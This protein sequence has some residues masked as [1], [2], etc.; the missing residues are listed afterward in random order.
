MHHAGGKPT[1]RHIGS[2]CRGARA[3]TSATCRSASRS[4][5][6]PHPAAAAQQ[7]MPVEWVHVRSL[8]SRF[9]TVC[10]VPW[11]TKTFNHNGKPIP[12][13]LFALS[14]VAAAAAGRLAAPRNQCSAAGRQAGRHTPHT[15]Q[16]T[17]P[18]LWQASRRNGTPCRRVT[19]PTAA[20]SYTRPAVYSAAVAGH[21]ARM[22]DHLDHSMQVWDVLHER[23]ASRGSS[24]CELQAAK[25][26]ISY[27][28]AGQNIDYSR[29]ANCTPELVAM[30]LT[31]TS[32]GLGPDHIIRS[33]SA[34]S[35]SPSDVS[36]TTSMVVPKRLHA[37]A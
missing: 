14:T 16:H 4:P 7:Q 15:R 24:S 22:H 19:L 31:A 20:T 5:A 9:H 10:P 33:S 35:T 28:L 12:S 8:L 26:G 1:W 6:P 2:R 32:F 36:G 27:L 25:V 23:Q 21:I 17:W 34:T 29:R 11:Y 37:C 18:T 13:C 3:G 30:W